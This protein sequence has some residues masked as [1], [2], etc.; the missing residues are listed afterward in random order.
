MTKPRSRGALFLLGSAPALSANDDDA[1]GGDASPRDGDANG[2]G[3]N[4]D[5]ARGGPS[6]P[7]AA[8]ADRPQL[9]RPMRA[10]RL[11]SAEPRFAPKRPAPAAR[12]WQ[13]RQAPQ[14]PRPFRS[15][16]SKQS[17]VACNFLPSRSEPR[18]RA[19]LCRDERVVNRTGPHTH[20][21]NRPRTV[22]SARTSNH[23]RLVSCVCHSGASR[24]DEPGIHNPCIPV[25]PR[26]LSHGLWIPGL[27]QTA[28]PGMTKVLGSRRPELFCQHQRLA[29]AHHIRA[30]AVEVGDQTFHLHARA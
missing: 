28:H 23:K 30:V 7:A 4:G 14:R 2:G 21:E 16:V 20:I 24:S 19:W 10:A 27:R 13:R 6:V 3:A 29:G 18:R 8:S 25:Q 26:T 11:P 9:A 17:E 22:A 15:R 1:S 12:H 5:G